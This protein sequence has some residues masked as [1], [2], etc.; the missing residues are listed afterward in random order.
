MKKCTIKSNLC[1]DSTCEICPERSLIKFLPD[2]ETSL[3]LKF[4]EKNKI[5]PKIIPKNSNKKYLFD[6]NKCKHKDILK[7]INK[8]TGCP[9]CSG[10]SLCSDKECKPCYNRS[11]ASSEKAQYWSDS[12]KLL[13]FSIDMSLWDNAPFSVTH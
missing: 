4:S 8:K 13:P 9:Y 12:N 5:D 1:L 6:C 3:N 2:I 11:F 7:A 10:N